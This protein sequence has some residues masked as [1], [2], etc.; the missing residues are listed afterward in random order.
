LDIAVYRRYL[1]QYVREGLANSNGTNAGIAEY[2][3]S[4]P[5]KFGWL[6]KHKDERLRA[7]MDARKAFEE[8]RHWPLDIVLSHLG[9][10][11]EELR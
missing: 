10:D 8:H 1:N 9:V 6:A 2:L 7:L 11:Q 4:L 3:Q 5:T